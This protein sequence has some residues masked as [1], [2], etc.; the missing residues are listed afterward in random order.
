MLKREG[1]DAAVDVRGVGGGEGVG[2]GAETNV[3]EFP[4]GAL[5]LSVCVC[6]C[7]CVR[8]CVCVREGE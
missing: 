1:D 4:G 8:L 2:D 7:A 5:T 6:V 3:R